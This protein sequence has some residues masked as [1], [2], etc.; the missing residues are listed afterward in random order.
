MDQALAAV[1]G[2]FV[3]AAKLLDMRP[4]TFRSKVFYHPELRSKWGHKKTGRPPGSP[5][6][7][8]Q[9]VKDTPAHRAARRGVDF[10]MEIVACLPRERQQELQQWLAVKLTSKE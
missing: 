4:G 3:L 10:V 9:A 1:N 7:Q 8:V 6:L 5:K 2:S